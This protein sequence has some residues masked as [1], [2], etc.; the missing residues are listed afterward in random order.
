MSEVLTP[1]QIVWLEHPLDRGPRGQAAPTSARRALRPA[2]SR[3]VALLSL[4]VF[5]GAQLAGTTK[6]EQPPPLVI[7]ECTLEAG[8]TAQQRAVT[9]DAN[10]RWVHGQTCQGTGPT[11]Q[12]YSSGNCY[13]AGCTCT[14]LAGPSYS[15]CV[16]P[17]GFYTCSGAGASTQG[18]VATIMKESVRAE[19]PGGAGVHS[20][21]AAWVWAAVPAALAVAAAVAAWAR[22]RRAGGHSLLRADEGDLLERA[23]LSDEACE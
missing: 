6:E 21:R 11:A 5:A 12:C 19:G 22:G 8:C 1:W 16:P 23:P 15:Q 18:S 20:P 3:A 7:A 9:L 14:D 4:P 13:T 10:W 17:Q 2:M